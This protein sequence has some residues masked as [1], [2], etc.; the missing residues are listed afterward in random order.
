MEGNGPER[1]RLAEELLQEAVYRSRGAQAGTGLFAAGDPARA[2]C[3]LGA[4]AE[5]VLELSPRGEELFGALW[6]AGLDAASARAVGER[7]SAWIERQDALDRERNHF[8]KAF[9]RAHGSDRSSYDAEQQAAFTAGLDRVN[10]KV[11]AERRAAAAALLGLAPA[12]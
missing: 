3:G 2:D 4:Q 10:A 5:V 6:P 1:L 8:L 12:S 7:T 11:E 9:R